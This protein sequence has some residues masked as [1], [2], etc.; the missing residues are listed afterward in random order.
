MDFISD[1]ACSCRISENFLSRGTLYYSTC[2]YGPLDTP[3]DV[4]D[5]LLD[6]VPL[7]LRVQ[8]CLVS[9]QGSH[10]GQAKKHTQDPDQGRP[11]QD[12]DAA[13]ASSCH[14]SVLSLSRKV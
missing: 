3:F 4:L 1:I 2:L 10:V 11:T 9:H 7:G 5:V 8:I 6:G 14:F 12:R 13:A